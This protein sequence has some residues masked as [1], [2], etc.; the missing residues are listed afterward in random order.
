MATKISLEN[1]I[2]NTGE[3]KLDFFFFTISGNAEP[4]ARLIFLSLMELE[5][6]WR[7]PYTEIL[8]CLTQEEIH[9][10]KKLDSEKDATAYIRSKMIKEDFPPL[11]SMVNSFM[12]SIAKNKTPSII[13]L[14]NSLFAQAK[15]NKSIE[16][17]FKDVVDE[18]DLTHFQTA[19][20]KFNFLIGKAFVDKKE[21][22]IID[23]DKQKIFWS[24]ALKINS[25]FDVADLAFVYHNGGIKNIHNALANSIYDFLVELK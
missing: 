24:E 23:S 18:E 22:Y 25:L 6:Y 14:F 10:I 17:E 12:N 9:E 11:E 7:N 1:V 13:E 16:I 2:K 8:E 21:K 15:K 4:N 5:R 20:D 19:E 3:F